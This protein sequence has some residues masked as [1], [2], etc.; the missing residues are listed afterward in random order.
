MAFPQY[1][2][3]ITLGGLSRVHFYRLCNLGKVFSPYRRSFSPV[4]NEV[5]G[6]SKIMSASGQIAHT[7][8]TATVATNGN[9]KKHRKRCLR[10]VMWLALLGWRAL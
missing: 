5:I 1:G 2:L 10:E 7:R 3:L 4:E 6:F 9:R 8:S